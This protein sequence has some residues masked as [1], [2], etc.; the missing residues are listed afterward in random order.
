MPSKLK[1]G[2]EHVQAELDF[3]LG[4]AALVCKLLRSHEPGEPVWLPGGLCDAIANTLEKT[5]K[6]YVGRTG[7]RRK[8]AGVENHVVR[9]VDGYRS[10]GMSLEHAFR[11]AA[12]AYLYDE[13]LIRD[14]YASWRTKQRKQT[15]R[16][17]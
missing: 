1:L 15:K 2:I 4:D 13:N 17:K 7:A 6:L 12:D 14:I 11:R 10:R 16:E 5:R 9:L 8:Y 3:K